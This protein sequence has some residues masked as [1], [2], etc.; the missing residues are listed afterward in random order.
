MGR[1]ITVTRF[2]RPR[3][4]VGRTQKRVPQW[5]NIILLSRQLAL[6][7]TQVVG[8]SA[9]GA[10]FSEKTTIIRVRG[11]ATV[12]MDAGAIADSM[13]VG[14]GLLVV[15]NNAFTVGGASSMPSP[16]DDPE[17]QFL[18]HQLF[19]LGPSVSATDDA[20]S[21][22]NNARVEIDSKAMRKVSPDETLAFIWDATILAGTPTADVQAFARFLILQT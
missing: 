16:I 4:I 6:D 13:V 14:L 10:G 1:D 2:S 22:V 3:A 20:S 5:S 21:I 9:A 17:A 15:R 7:A 12:A 8:T 18:Y 19:S 11:S